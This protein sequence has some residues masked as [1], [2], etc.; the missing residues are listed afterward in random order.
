MS[1]SLT[2]LGILFPNVPD[3][4]IT[5]K[6]IMRK[7]VQD[8]V[9]VSVSYGVGNV[10]ADMRLIKWVLEAIVII[11]E[12]VS[13]HTLYCVMSSVLNLFSVLNMSIDSMSYLFYCYNCANMK[14][15]Q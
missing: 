10:P 6:S 11:Q 4:V 5:F 7:I 3:E 1:L 15:S 9:C 13:K 14:C 12:L 2:G 8:R